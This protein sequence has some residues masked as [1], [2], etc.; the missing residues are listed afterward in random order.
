[1]NNRGKSICSVLKTVRK[2]IADANE[3][4]FETQKCHFK[5]ECR[6]TCPAC[7]AEVRYIESELGLRKAAGKI[8]MVAGIS[9]GLLALSPVQVNAQSVS[10]K[11]KPSTERTRGEAAVQEAKATSKVVN[12]T[13]ASCNKV[14]AGIIEQSPSFPGG[15][16]ALMAFVAN[17]LRYRQDVQ[18]NGLQGR[19]VV[20]FM[21]EKD[22][23]ITEPK[24]VR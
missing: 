18:G 14:L 16:A 21:V 8:I 13:T 15:P 24:V 5:G 17:N 23:T 6:G 4:P 19:V 7:E 10:N 22:G 2:Q 3:I 20:S 11:R 9:A 12:D 1:M